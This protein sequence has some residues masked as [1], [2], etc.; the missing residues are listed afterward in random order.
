MGDIIGNGFRLSLGQYLNRDKLEI[1]VD[2]MQSE[3][4]K[5]NIIAKDCFDYKSRESIKLDISVNPTRSIEAIAKDIQ[6]RLLP[7][8]RLAFI[9]QKECLE[10]R[11]KADSDKLQRETTIKSLWP[12]V[13]QGSDTMYITSNVGS[14]NCRIYSGGEINEIKIN[15]E[16]NEY[17]FKILGFIKSLEQYEGGINEQE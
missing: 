5:H 11:I 6:S 7:N 2:S 3:D 1:R 10:S 13:Y 8:A 17:A 14:V 15:P 9:K 4:K 12:K 16:N